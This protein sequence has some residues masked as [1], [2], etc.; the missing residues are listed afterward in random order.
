MR[1]TISVEKFKTAINNC[2]ANSTCDEPEVRHGMIF[3]LELV[4]FETGNYNGYKYLPQDQVPEDVLPGVRYDLDG[5]IL[6]YEKRFEN[7]DSTRRHYF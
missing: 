6:P 1:K 3:A 2:L 7:T 4:L 5:N